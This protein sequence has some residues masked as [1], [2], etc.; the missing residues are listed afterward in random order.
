MTATSLLAETDD[1]DDADDEQAVTNEAVL[2]DVSLSV[3][4]SADRGEAAAIAVAI[5][6]HLRD[7]AAAAANADEVPS[8]HCDRWSLSG[9]LDGRTPPRGVAHGEEW[10]TAGRL[11][12]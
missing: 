6:A 5:G 4:A 1:V 8:E 10:K 9:R 3:P 11:R 2:D 7:R 12:R